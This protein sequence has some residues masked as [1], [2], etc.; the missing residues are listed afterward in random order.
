[1]SNPVELGKVKWLRSMEDAMVQSKRECKPIL[2]LFQEIPG[3]QTC[4]QYGNEVLSHPLIVEAI[5]THFVPLAIYNNKGGD[6]AAIL[7]KFNEP[8]WNNP[9]VRIVDE[10]GKDLIP[11]LS[12][13]YSPQGLS[14]AMTNV[15]INIQG[16]APVYLQLLTDELVAKSKGFQSATYSMY[17]FW[18]GEA[19]FGKVNGVMMTSAGFQNG[20]EVVKV[21]YDPS[22]ITKTQLDKI[23]SQSSCRTSASGSF[24]PDNTPKYY[25]SNSYYRGIPMTE[26]QKCKVNSAIAEGQDPD[27]YLSPRQLQF[28]KRGLAENLVSLELINAWSKA[29]KNR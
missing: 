21:D 24:S 13:N 6:D 29:E 19:L 22:I 16:K 28:L 4:R 1:M 3:C 15:L 11:R 12:G 25:L 14:S 8:A 10:K 7:K 23:A 26:L 17:C 2:I 5:E 20:K 27:I 9:V 18:S